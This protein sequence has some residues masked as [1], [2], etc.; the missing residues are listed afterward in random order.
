MP[1]SL[2]S[3]VDSARPQAQPIEELLDET[4]CRSFLFHVTTGYA[5][6]RHNGVAIGKRDFMGAY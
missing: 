5:I 6:L 1:L 4:D 2:A 3:D